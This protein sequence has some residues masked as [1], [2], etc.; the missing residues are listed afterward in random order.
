M[1]HSTRIRKAAVSGA[2]YPDNPKDLADT[3]KFFLNS[4][5]KEEKNITKENS[6]LKALIAPHAGYIYSGPVAGCSFSQ[7]ALAPNKPKDIVLIGPAHYVPVY[8]VAL[9]GADFFETPL[10]Q[11]KINNTLREKAV[12][13]FSFVLL[14]DEA[15]QPEHCLEVELPFLQIVL[16]NSFSIL[17]LL[18]GAISYQETAKLLSFLI[19]EG[20]FVIVSSDL[21]HYLDYE[22]AKKVDFQTAQYITSLKPELIE[23]EM[24]CGHTAIKALLEV[25]KMKGYTANTIKLANSGDTYGDKSKVVGYGAFSF[26]QNV[27]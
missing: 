15:H 26:F 25:S 7:L 16:E 17:P 5:L 8:G 11:I 27:H 9:S 14:E 3:V 2:F 1:A 19:E 22:T 13:N 20:A 10:G 24:A 18:T 12:K 23:S 21:S 4:A 6:K